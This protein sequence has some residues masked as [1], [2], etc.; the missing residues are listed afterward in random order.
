WLF[1][2][3]DLFLRGGALLAAAAVAAPARR[4]ALLRMVD[5]DAR[6]LSRLKIKIAPLTSACLRAGA[7][8]SRGNGDG[9]YTLLT[10]AEA[11]FAA[12]SMAMYAA[13]ARRRR[14]ELLGG[15]DGRTLVASAD[16]E[17][18]AQEI[19]NPARMTAML[20]PGKW[21]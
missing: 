13:A 11:G 21:S 5:R 8:A 10:G 3:E 15:D 1:R 14:G 17:M 20:L 2:G 4:V 19:K 12:S 9:A 6:A 18:S 16:A 7:E